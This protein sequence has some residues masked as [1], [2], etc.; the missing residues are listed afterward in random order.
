MP[1]RISGTTAEGVTVG[2]DLTELEISIITSRSPAF[3]RILL[4][5]LDSIKEYESKQRKGEQN[6]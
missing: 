3:A 6:E 2:R 4:Q 5:L 1:I